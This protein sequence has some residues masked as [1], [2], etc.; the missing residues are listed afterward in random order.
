MDRAGEGVTRSRKCANQAWL[1]SRKRIMQRA[2]H[3]SEEPS[4][5]TA[6]PPRNFLETPSGRIKKH[7]SFLPDRRMVA[8]LFRIKGLSEAG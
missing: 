3:I 4:E 8:A 7:P 6:S 5:A 2:I 1:S